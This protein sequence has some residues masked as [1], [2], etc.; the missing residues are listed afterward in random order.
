MSVLAVRER[1][2][3]RQIPFVNIHFVNISFLNVRANA[4]YTHEPIHFVPEFNAWRES[5]DWL[6]GGERVRYEELAEHRAAAAAAQTVLR[7]FEMRKSSVR[8][9]RRARLPGDE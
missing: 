7:L 3:D 9:M 4:G 1:Y 5:A 8:L 2:L 6:A